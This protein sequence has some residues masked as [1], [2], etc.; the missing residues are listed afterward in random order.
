MVRGHG[1]SDTC[2]SDCLPTDHLVLTN[3]DDGPVIRFDFNR[4]RTAL[5]GVDINRPQRFISRLCELCVLRETPHTLQRAVIH[6]RYRFAGNNGHGHAHALSYDGASHWILKQTREERSSK[7]WS[8]FPAAGG[9]Y[10]SFDL[11]NSSPEF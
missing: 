1:H 7:S 9:N 3:Y 11:H 6:R 10:S 5:H 4:F 8:R 2:H